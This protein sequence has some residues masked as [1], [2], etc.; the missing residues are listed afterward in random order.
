M[1]PQTNYIRCLGVTLDSKLNLNWHVENVTAKGN[2]TLGF[3]S[4]KNILTNFEA[5][6]NMA[7]KQLVLLV[8]LCLCCVLDKTGLSFNGRHI[9][10]IVL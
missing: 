2:S 3:Y 6:K 8:C 5:V 7:Y 9:K 4:E 10:P 1:V